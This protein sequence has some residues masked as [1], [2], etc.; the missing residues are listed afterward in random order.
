MRIRLG[1]VPQDPLI[2]SLSSLFIFY[3]WKQVDTIKTR[4]ESIVGAFN[5]CFQLAPLALVDNNMFTAPP[6]GRRS[7]SAAT[8]ANHPQAHP[9]AGS[10]RLHDI[11]MIVQK[12][13]YQYPVRVHSLNNVPYLAWNLESRSVLGAYLR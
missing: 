6:P 12:P 1:G 13:T 3:R 11:V 4:V 5:V 9:R 10:S 7:A 2:I 8:E